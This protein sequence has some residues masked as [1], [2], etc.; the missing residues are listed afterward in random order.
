MLQDHILRDSGISG[1]YLN[2]DNVL[3]GLHGTIQNFGVS[4]F[5]YKDTVPRKAHFLLKL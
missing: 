4:S 5:T 2:F 3:D 1:V